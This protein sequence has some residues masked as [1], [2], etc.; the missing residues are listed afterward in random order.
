MTPENIIAGD[1]V[2]NF[3]KEYAALVLIVPVVG[4]FVNRVVAQR[5]MKKFK[6]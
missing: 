6:S 4:Y 5:M 2:T 3:L 1:A